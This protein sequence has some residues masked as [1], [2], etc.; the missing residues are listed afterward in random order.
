MAALPLPLQARCQEP[1]SSLSL[2]PTRKLFRRRAGLREEV[3]EF[4]GGGREQAGV[5]GR[6]DAF[7]FSACGGGGGGGR[8]GAGGGFSPAGEF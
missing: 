7:L 1:A 8:G 5:F 2:S 6:P 4:R 3:V